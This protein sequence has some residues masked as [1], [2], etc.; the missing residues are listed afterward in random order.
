[1]Q[2]MAGGP[3][4]ADD[5]GAQRGLLHI[6]HCTGGAGARRARHYW[7][8]DTGVLGAGSASTWYAVYP[9]PTPPGPRPPGPAPQLAAGGW[10]LAV[11]WRGCAVCAGGRVGRGA[12]GG[13]CWGF[14]SFSS[15]AH[16]ALLAAAHPPL[17]TAAAAHS[18]PCCCC[19]ALRNTKE[20]GTALLHAGT[21]GEQAE[22]KALAP[23]G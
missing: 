3:V 19:C 12:C 18:T 7:I 20:E 22:A 8:L 16:S 21:K 13:G 5:S 17:R 23:P 4:M 6:A 1:V 11:G 9:P 2:V 15:P 10:R 14:S